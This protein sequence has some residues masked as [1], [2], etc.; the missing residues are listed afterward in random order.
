MGEPELARL[1]FEAVVTIDPSNKAALSHIN[2]CKQKLKEQKAREK[3]I[4]A[5][6]FDKFAQQDREVKMA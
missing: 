4:Y 3:K 1:D 5:N 2:I 6:M